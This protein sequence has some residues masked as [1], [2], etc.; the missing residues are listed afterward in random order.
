VELSTS[1]QDGTRGDVRLL[2][3]LRAV[4]GLREEMDR[5]RAVLA[6]AADLAGRHLGADP[7]TPVTIDEFDAALDAA[8]DMVARRF[9]AA[10]HDEDTPRL[11]AL[12][13]QISHARVNLRQA[14]LVRR[15]EAIAGVHRTLDALRTV[16]SISDLVRLAPTHVG[17]LGF[18]RCMVSR[19]HESSWIARTCYVSE[20]PQLADAIVAVGR[21]GLRLDHQLIESEMVRRRSALLVR[22]AQDN[23]RVNPGFKRV[24]CTSSYVAAPILAGGGVLGFVHADTPVDGR[25][26]EEFDR[27]VISIFSECI[28]YAVER[29][30]FQDRLRRIRQQVQA[31]SNSVPD[32]LDEM[33]AANED[34]R[35][36]PPPTAYLRTGSRPVPSGRHRNGIDT[37]T[38]REIEVLSHMAEGDTN[39]RIANRLVV[40]EATVK[41]HVQHILRKLGA[42]N[43]AEAVSR[44]LRA[45]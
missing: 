17:K 15:S 18:H 41:A 40:S 30:H 25:E 20:D 22:K 36:L 44:Y 37:L 8:Q 39:A 19:V 4:G 42:A 34:P 9:Q 26:V 27:M 32:M 10:P 29:L 1:L 31:V 21:D 45:V 13:H 28:G 2:P 24:T 6:L 38:R 14:Q 3:A 23:E 33:I 35:P 43:R 12:S 7:L 16:E 11:L 5:A